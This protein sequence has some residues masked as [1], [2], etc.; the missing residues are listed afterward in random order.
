MPG[1]DIIS[2]NGKL[3]PEGETFVAWSVFGFEAGERSDVVDCSGRVLGHAVCDGRSFPHRNMGKKKN[4][5]FFVEYMRHD[6][7][8]LGSG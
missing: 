4:F 1:V 8:F 5:A 6:T 7:D 2:V 3:L